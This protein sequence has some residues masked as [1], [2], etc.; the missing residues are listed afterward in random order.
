MSPLDRWW[1]AEPRSLQPQHVGV[2]LDRCYRG[3]GKSTQEEKA[4]PNREGLYD[5]AIRA[6]RPGSEL[7]KGL[8]A[9][10]FAYWRES[11][12]TPGPYR[13][14]RVL[15]LETTGRMLLH[16]STGSTPT[17]GSVLL[18][19]TYGVP[20]LPGSGLK[21]MARAWARSRESAKTVSELFGP[22]R[23]TEHDQAAL[24]NF[25]DALWVP[26]LRPDAPEWSPVELDV[27]TP[28]HSDYYTGDQPPAD[29]Q[30]P[31]PTNRLAVAKGARFCVILEGCQAEPAD[32]EPWLDKAEELL[33]EAA[34]ELGFGAYTRAGYGRL[35]SESARTSKAEA[36]VQRTWSSATLSL[37][38]GSGR[39]TALLSD[40]R[41]AF[42]DGALAGTLRASLSPEIAAR[43]KKHRELKRVNVL[44]EPV[45]TALRIVELRAT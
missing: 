45:G 10:R 29:W 25:L 44:V 38:P 35:G 41:R 3:D 8:Y 5:A 17:D 23:D 7:V 9:P 14:V 21:G 12:G 1:E 32:I 34:R 22:E 24:V 6:L 18:H 15:E 20:Y 33:T 28:H 42:A 11:L 19:H 31:I 39:L 27:V 37:D 4:K 26:R 2:W 43:L 13:A 16:P 36:P 30:Q 40:G